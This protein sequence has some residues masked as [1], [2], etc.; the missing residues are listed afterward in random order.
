MEI[1]GKS[2]I[3]TGGGSGIGAGLA[4]R[5]AQEGAH[6]IIC[7]RRPEALDR[8]ASQG[9]GL[10][11]EIVPVPADI[12]HETDV[13]KLVTYAVTRFGN[14]D[15]LVNNAGVG[16]G[17]AIHTHSVADWDRVMAINLRGPFLLARAVLRHMRRQ[18]AGEIVQI[19]SEAG[20]V[21]YTGSGAYGVSKFALNALGEFIQMENQD[22]GIRVHH[23][24][25]GMV[26]SEMTEDSPGLDRD[27]CL[28][29][30]DIADLAVFLVSRRPNVKIGRPVLIQTMEN[31]WN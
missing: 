22:H 12:G 24:C 23:I 10:P 17:G 25:P 8:T 28:T 29:P 31:P 2:V 9:A 19:S 15:I 7:G 6:V 13:E 3:I 18:Q 16:G 21:H 27:K 20:L 26:I 5:F 1:Q 14:I 4:T 11:G 30:Q